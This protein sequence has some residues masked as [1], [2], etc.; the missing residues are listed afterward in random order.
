MT[1]P[2]RTPARAI[3]GRHLTPIVKA[4]AAVAAGAAIGSLLYQVL[5]ERADRRRFPPPGELLDVRGRRVHVWLEGDGDGPALVVVPGIG[6]DCLEWAVI[7]RQLVPDHRVLLYDRGGLGWSDWV[8]GPRT[9]S[10]LADEL[11]AVLEAAAVS[12][13]YILVGHSLGGAIIRLYTARHPERVAGLILVDSTHELST[14]KAVQEF[15]W[16]MGDLDRWRRA[17]IRYL[18]PLGIERA[19]VRLLGYRYYH[20]WAAREV[21]ADLI[22]T[23]VALNLT[24]PCFERSRVC[25]VSVIVERRGLR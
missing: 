25:G 16:R 6:T 8:P 12:G 17:V 13:P 23:S 10:E 18:K 24:R 15:G 1:F 22:E 7:Q 11:H 2:P 20:D 21:P 9:A 4:A 19:R 5:G 14:E 3:R